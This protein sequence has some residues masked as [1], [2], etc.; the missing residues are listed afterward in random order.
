MA[1][2]PDGRL[3]AAGSSDG[4]VWLWH[5]TDPAHP[6]RLGQPLTGPMNSAFSV[7]FSPDGK[8]LAAGRGDGTVR[9]WNLTDPAHPT[10]IGQ[11]LTGPTG[12][13]A[14]VAFSPDWKTLPPA[15]AMARWGCGTSPTRPTRPRSA[16]P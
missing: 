16:S 11:P 6:T 3:V 13:V 15:A 5:L 2:S 14:S 1:F 4:A 9:R 8:T 7:A 10:L 12:V